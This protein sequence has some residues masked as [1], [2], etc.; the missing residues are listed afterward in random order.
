MTGKLRS[1]SRENNE[2]MEDGARRTIQ[3]PTC[4]LGHCR[5]KEEAMR[6][7]TATK[8]T[9]IVLGWSVRPSVARAGS[10][11]ECLGDN[12]KAPMCQIRD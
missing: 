4:W 3:C 2:L 1:K 11:H 10:E 12:W 9:Y 5:M 6:G 8:T 7:D